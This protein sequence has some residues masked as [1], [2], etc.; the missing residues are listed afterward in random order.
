M[1]QVV[2]LCREREKERGE[3][4]AIPGLDA[5]A[6][7]LPILRTLLAICMAMEPTPPAPAVIS[8][9]LFLLSSSSSP[10]F[11]YLS[12]V[13]WLIRR[14]GG[15]H[16]GHTF[17]YRDANAINQT[18]PSCEGGERF[19]SSLKKGE[20]ARLPAHYPFINQGVLCIAP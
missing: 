4:S 17:G 16:D 18:F 7:T 6:I 10:E 20:P 1:V 15:D 9:T 8:S 5:V 12:V 11:R 14:K 2:R 13:V 19:P 3:S